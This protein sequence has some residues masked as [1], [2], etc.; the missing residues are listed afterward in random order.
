MIDLILKL[1]STLAGLGGQLHGLKRDRRDRIAGLMTSIADCVA[2]IAAQFR[3][4]EDLAN[5]RC[6]ELLLYLN[7]LEKIVEGIITDDQLHHLIGV[8]ES[9]MAGPFGL[10]MLRYDLGFRSA[11]RGMIDEKMTAMRLEKRKERMARAESSLL[12]LDAANGSF[13]A[14][15]NLLRAS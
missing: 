7:D 12:A 9:A 11:R 5:D 15:A 1:A 4:S 13:R 10:A 14:T 6:Y 3:A 8:L 2:D